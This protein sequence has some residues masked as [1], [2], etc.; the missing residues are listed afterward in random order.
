MSV[1]AFLTLLLLG[2]I[3]ATFGS[4]VGLGGG[5]IIVPALIYL[6]PLLLDQDISTTLAVGTSLTVLI[7]TALSSTLTYMKDKKVDFRSAWLYFVTSGPAAIL[8]A[9]LTKLF[10][11]QQFQLVF[12]VFMLCI[13]L[14]LIVRNRLKPSTREWRIQRTFTDAQGVQAQYGYNIPAALVVGFGVG[15]ISGL[16]G[17]GGGS[18]FVPAM[19]LMFRY[20]A[21]VATAT[22]MFV[23]FLSSILG[24]MT[25]W[26]NGDVGG[27]LVLALAPGAWL[28]G[29][30]GARIVRRISG[31]GLLWLLRVTLFVLAFKLIWSGLS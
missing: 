17:I 19:V 23:I 26:Y 7:F 22:S 31:N 6:G 12:G 28:G 18:L 4:I 13:S 2:A 1:L 14:L 29:W 21:H 11:P 5:I 3:S 24:S 8:G 15:L 30:L 25:H 27:W 10:D 9:S 16:F 20:P